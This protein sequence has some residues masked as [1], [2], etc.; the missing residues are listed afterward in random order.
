MDDADHREPF[1]G[2]ASI[3]LGRGTRPLQ[4]LTFP[5]ASYTCEGL[6]YQLSHDHTHSLSRDYQAIFSSIMIKQFD[7]STVNYDE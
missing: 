3:W 7:V 5:Y 1:I 2:Y 6:V 4:Y